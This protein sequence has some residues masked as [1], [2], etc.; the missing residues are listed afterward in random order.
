MTFCFF[1]NNDSKLFIPSVFKYA[2]SSD[3]AK[4]WI[5][6]KE[7]WP[8]LRSSV[9]DSPNMLIFLPKMKTVC[10]LDLHGVWFANMLPNYVI[11]IHL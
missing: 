5:V 6:K 10:T 9:P 4:D 11:N 8:T 3:S 1:K 7:K 2:E